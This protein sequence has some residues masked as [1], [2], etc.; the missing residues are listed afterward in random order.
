MPKAHRFRKFASVKK[1]INPNDCRLSSNKAKLEEKLKKVEESR[2]NYVAPIPTSMFLSHNSALAPPY[3]VLV[4]TNFLHLSTTNRIDLIRGMLDCLYAKAIPCV[5]DCVFVELEKLGS[6]YRLALNLARDPRVERLPCS[7]SGSYADDCIVQRVTS[8][9]CFIVAT[10]DRGLRRR[11][12]KIP[13][14]PLM[15]IK[16]K[17]YAIE[18]LPD[19]G[20]PS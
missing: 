10:C 6:R 7:H 19:S 5:S 14:V 17:Q 3:R 11:L 9:R 13:G 18:R 20:L 12:R 8:H 15:F 2:K 4:D 1:M 16:K